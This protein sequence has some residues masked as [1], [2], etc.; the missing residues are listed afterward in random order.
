MA[1]LKIK[2]IRVEQT[3][4]FFREGS[5]LAGTLRAG[6]LGLESRVEIESDEPEERI[7][8]MMRM[9]E[10]SCFTLGSLTGAVPIETHLK[11]NGR[12]LAVEESTP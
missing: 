6:C 1:K 12:S 8:E 9:G 2:G 5:A 4:R 10:R 3:I 11:L 7:R